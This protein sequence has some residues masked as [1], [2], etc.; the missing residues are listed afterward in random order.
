MC[1][2]MR[3]VPCNHCCPEQEKVTLLVSFSFS[4]LSYSVP[5][6]S[7][8]YQKIWSD[9]SPSPVASPPC[10]CCP[11]TRPLSKL[12]TVIRRSYFP[13]CKASLLNLLRVIF[14]FLLHLFRTFL[15][16][17][18]HTLFSQ[19][20][21][22][23]KVPI[24]IYSQSFSSVSCE[25]MPRLG[26]FVMGKEASLSSL[27][28][29]TAFKSALLLSL[30]GINFPESTVEVFK[31]NHYQ[32]LISSAW[33]T[34]AGFFLDHLL[35]TSWPFFLHFRTFPRWNYSVSDWP[36]STHLTVWASLVKRIARYLSN[37]ANISIRYSSQS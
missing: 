31:E 32:V 26:I 15:W 25:Q 23:E 13:M 4:Y 14:Y 29:V 30:V 18:F 2:S 3:T 27:G 5:I 24:G 33:K 20:Y 37:S 34:S 1:S 6:A 11:K 7:V 16:A 9:S 8:F 19:S 10:P 22:S 17:H 35:S 21:C 36:R 12:R 28:F